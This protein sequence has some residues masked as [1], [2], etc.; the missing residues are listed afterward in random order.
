M[1][2]NGEPLEPPLY[3]Q[4][5]IGL[6]GIMWLAEC[7][8]DEVAEICSGGLANPNQDPNIWPLQYYAKN[9]EKLTETLGHGYSSKSTQQELSNEYQHDRD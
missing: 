6:Q 8:C 5:M 4:L 3:N 7:E 1:N 9:P 2:L